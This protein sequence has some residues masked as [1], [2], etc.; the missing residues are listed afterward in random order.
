MLRGLSS[1][2]IC[3]LL[4]VRLVTS[5]SFQ[6][7]LRTTF[8]ND[9]PGLWT[10]VWSSDPNQCPNT[11]QHLGYTRHR[12]GAFRILHSHILHDGNRCTDPSRPSSQRAFRLYTDTAVR[13]KIAFPEGSYRVPKRL[14]QVLQDIGPAR[15]TRLAAEKLGERYYIGFEAV[16]RECNGTSVFKRGTS[17]I[18]LRPFKNALKVLTF[19]VT[20]TTDRKWLVM[21]PYRKKACVYESP[22]RE[23]NDPSSGTN[24]T[25]QEGDSDKPANENVLGGSD[26]DGRHCFPV[27]AMVNVQ[28]RGAIR[29]SEL[30]VGDSVEVKRGVYS[31]VF[32]FTHQDSTPRVQFVT[33]ETASGEVASLTAGHFLYVNTVLKTAFTVNTG[34]RVIL[35]DGR[36]SAVIRVGIKFERGLYNP[37]TLHGDIVV[38]G[39]RMS[40]YTWTVAPPLAHVLLSPLRGLYR[41]LTNDLLFS[42]G[43]G[44]V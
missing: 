39:I 44:T 14:L 2:V 7:P 42:V 33:L 8:P 34:D 32:M 19:N 43:S 18:L 37:Q 17:A 40:T 30:K 1:F 11:I 26:S 27:N 5:L 10:L 16:D 31:R 6:N 20:F 28:R 38:N 21:V 15:K 12:E 36:E 23:E 3:L 25:T 41:L 22:L 29:M 35:A 13:R 9:I 4:S 24:E